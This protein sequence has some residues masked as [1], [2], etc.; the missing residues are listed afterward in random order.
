MT[1]KRKLLGEARELLAE[2]R[3]GRTPGGDDCQLTDCLPLPVRLEVIHGQE[4]AIK[5]RGTE[6]LVEGDLR[7]VVWAILGEWHAARPRLNRALRAARKKAG[8]PPAS[9]YL[10]RVCDLPMPQEV[11]GLLAGWERRA[12]LDGEGTGG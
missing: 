7:P 5:E 8:I 4:R 3:G 12:A 2:A 11:K 9:P 1:R 6:D 10:A